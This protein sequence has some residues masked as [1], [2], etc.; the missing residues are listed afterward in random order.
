MVFIIL[1]I[2]C[3][4]IIV[5]NSTALAHYSSGVERSSWLMLLR[6]VL[7]HTSLLW[8]SHCSSRPKSWSFAVDAVATA[9]FRSWGR[10]RQKALL[11]GF[12]LFLFILLNSQYICK[13]D[14]RFFS[15]LGCQIFMFQVDP[16]FC[17]LFL[18]VICL[19]NMT[20]L[21]FNYFVVCSWISYLLK[22][23]ACFQ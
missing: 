12:M 3:S 23:A 4:K 20:S 9:R 17:F 15:N 6:G 2:S 19:F 14:F 1:L 5:V 7:C 22:G 11:F 8:L 18:N 13:Y 21:Q 10:R 16:D